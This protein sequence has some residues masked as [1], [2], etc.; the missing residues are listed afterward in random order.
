VC[1]EVKAQTQ[2]VVAV[3]VNL[4]FAQALQLGRSE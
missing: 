3:G 2:L 1:S 4:Y